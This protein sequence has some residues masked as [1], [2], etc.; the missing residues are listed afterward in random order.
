MRPKIRS[1]YVSSSISGTIATFFG[2]IAVVLVHMAGV[3]F[4]TYTQALVA[5]AIASFLSGFF[6]RYFALKERENSR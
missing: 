5:V 3:S 2:V 1:V 6:G 4:N